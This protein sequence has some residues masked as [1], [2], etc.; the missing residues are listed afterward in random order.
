[1]SQPIGNEGRICPDGF[2]VWSDTE[3]TQLRLLAEAAP[4][5]CQAVAWVE[6]QDVELRRRDTETE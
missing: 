2:R 1:M 6:T 3:R 4:V 5:I